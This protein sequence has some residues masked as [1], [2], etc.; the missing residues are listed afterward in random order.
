MT[1]KPNVLQGA[2]LWVFGAGMATACA[3]ALLPIM[4]FLAPEKADFGEFPAYPVSN[5]LGLTML[6]SSFVTLT[7]AYATLRRQMHMTLPTG[8]K[9]SLFALGVLVNN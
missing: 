7:A 5:M 2:F 1:I 6:V 9:A 8:T 4:I 3:L